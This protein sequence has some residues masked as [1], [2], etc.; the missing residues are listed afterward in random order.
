M[1]HKYGYEFRKHQL[2]SAKRK[3]SIKQ[4]REEYSTAE[5]L[6]PELP[7]SNLGHKGEASDEIYFGH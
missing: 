7:A 4:F 5:F 2:S 3:I 1:G 6:D